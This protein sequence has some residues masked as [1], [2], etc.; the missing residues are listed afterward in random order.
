MLPLQKIPQSAHSGGEGPVYWGLSKSSHY[1]GSVW[2]TQGSE[3]PAPCKILSRFLFASDY[4][5]YLSYKYILRPQVHE[6]ACN[7]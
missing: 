6:S 1:P 2:G 5:T 4:L 3:L 7:E